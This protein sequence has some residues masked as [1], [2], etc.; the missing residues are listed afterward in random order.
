MTNEPTT[1]ASGEVTEADVEQYMTSLSN[2]GRWGED[3]RLGTLNLITNETRLAAAQTVKTG[4]AISLS[5]NIDPLKADTLGSGLS[6]VQR[7]MGLH[8][9]G[10]HLEGE[11]VRFDAVTEY[12]GISA[13]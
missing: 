13:H 2:W 9:A 3:D 4:K 11:S 8:E 6:L 5:R 1:S 12:V 7:F 10:D